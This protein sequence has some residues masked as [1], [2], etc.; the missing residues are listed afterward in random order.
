MLRHTQIYTNN[1]MYGMHVR[2]PLRDTCAFR[3]CDV[4]IEMLHLKKES[5]LHSGKGKRQM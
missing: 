4:H 3:V 2:L 5:E 1:F